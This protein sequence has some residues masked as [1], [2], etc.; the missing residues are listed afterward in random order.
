MVKSTSSAPLELRPFPSLLRSLRL[1][2]LQLVRM[3]GA[4]ANF[5]AMADALHVT[6]PAITKMAH[7]LERTLGAPV[8]ERSASGVRLSAFGQSVLSQVQRS[9]AHL[10]QLAEDL[11]IHHEGVGAALR[12]GSPTFTA[13][14]LLAR[15]IAHWMQLN[16]RG[17]VIMSDDVSARLLARLLSGDLDAVI[18][19]LDDASCSDDGLQQLHFERLY[20]DAVTFVTSVDTPG[21]EGLES[22]AELCKLPWVMPPRNSQVW[23][24]LRRELMLSGHKQPYGVV[25]S[26][27]IPAIGAILNHAPG[28][29]GALRADAGR[30]LSQQHQGLRLLTVTPK[31]ALPS[32]GILRLRSA[33]PDAI[34]ESLLALLRQEASSMFTN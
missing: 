34:L 31:V 14:S 25:E 5:R 20:E 22:L 19:S 10:D 24:A 29:I 33:A 11:P 26:S 8:F 16:P 21:L 28:T 1:P 12:I 17:R 6:Q 9:L 27:S 4:G 15:P 30:Y 32:V 2:Q 7:E 13:A 18:G 23:M 3:A